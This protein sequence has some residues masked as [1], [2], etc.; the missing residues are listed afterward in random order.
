MNYIVLFLMY[1]VAIDFAI[2]LVHYIR[3]G[4][5]VN[6]DFLAPYRYMFRKRAQ[7]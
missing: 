7:K 4:E 3:T 1:L 6:S 5:G 2:H